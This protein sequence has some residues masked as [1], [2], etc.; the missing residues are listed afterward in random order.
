MEED[1]VIAGLVARNF[2]IAIVPYMDLLLRLDV[3]ILTI[4]NPV[5]KRKIY[6]VSSA[7][8]Y[9]PPAVQLFRE[10]VTEQDFL[11]EGEGKI[12]L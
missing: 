3:Q 12:V 2:G 9:L 10:Y 8:S 6:M 5:Y 7:N 1:Q 4:T 11:G